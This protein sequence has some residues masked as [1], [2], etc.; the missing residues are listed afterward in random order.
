MDDA[1]HFLI[2]LQSLKTEMQNIIVQQIYRLFLDLHR[3]LLSVKHN[4]QLASFP[5]LLHQPARVGFLKLERQR[6]AQRAAENTS[7]NK[8]QPSQL[9]CFHGK[10]SFFHCDHVHRVVPPNQILYI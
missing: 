9:F 4:F 2:R 7:R 1:V 5:L 8:P 6:F 3:Y 10:I